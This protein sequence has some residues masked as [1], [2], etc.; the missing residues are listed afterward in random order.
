MIGRDPDNKLFVV[1][2]RQQPFLA[3]AI[4]RVAAKAPVRLLVGHEGG[5]SNEEDWTE[6]SD[7]YAFMEAKIPGLY[8]GVEDY[9]QHH[10]PTDVFETMTYNF[11]V[12]AVETLIEAVT[13][14]DAD[15]DAIVA[16]TG[17][18]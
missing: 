4:A 5:T 8:F 13:E 18:H 1:G 9:A 2:L 6:D 16:R 17:A 14:F 12:G 10:K 7:Q 15:A 11:Y 3:G